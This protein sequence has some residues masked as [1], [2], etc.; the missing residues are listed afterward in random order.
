MT[1][2]AH[3]WRHLRSFRTRFHQLCDLF[4]HHLVGGTIE[5]SLKMEERSTT[6]D[7]AVP[8]GRES[9]RF[10]QLLRVF[11]HPEG[12]LFF[13]TL[14]ADFL[15]VAPV[16]NEERAALTAQQ[17]STVE[18]P[19]PITVNQ[20]TL[21]GPRIFQIVADSGLLSEDPIQVRNMATLQAMPMV[22]ELVLFNFH[23]YCQQVFGLLIYLYSVVRRLEADGV[24]LSPPLPTLAQPC[25]IYCLSTGPE[26]DFTTMEHVYPESLGN[27][28]LILPKGSVCQKCNNTILSD[29][30]KYLVEHDPINLLRVFFV[31]WNPKTGKY[32]QARSQ[33][34]TIRRSAPREIV[35]EPHGL[36]AQDLRQLRDGQIPWLGKRPF[37][38]IALG[39]SLFKIGLG[40]V[41]HQVGHP[42]ALDSRYDLARSFIRGETDFPNFLFMGAQFLPSPKI[43]GILRCDA[44]GSILV[45][46]I[47]GLVFCF[48]LEAMPVLDPSILPAEPLMLSYA[49][50]TQENE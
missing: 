16:T 25:C 27:Q 42:A 45:T 17:K 39:R 20:E 6:T 28:D 14:V 8:G 44:Q 22:H 4:S 5:V 47:F 24:D 36:S 13:P 2:N 38:P 1:E 15:E 3:M 23:T 26:G 12:E 50:S 10:A 32:L 30:D 49:L 48:N 37:N 29:L 46:S 33:R 11:A 7:L 43:H 34:L 19:M 21:T 40:V 18:A 9:L 35:I 41:A 31:P